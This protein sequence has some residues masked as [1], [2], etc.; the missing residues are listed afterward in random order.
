MSNT[1]NDPRPI[2]QTPVGELLGQELEARGWSQADFA[3]VL[4]RPTQFVSEIIT[5]KKEI[6]RESAAQIG[7]AL[8]QSPE[9]WLKLQDQYLLSEQAKNATTQAKLDDVRRR[10]GLNRLAPI[11]LLQKR[12]VLSGRTLDE[13]EAEV[14]DLFDLDSIDSSPEFAAAAKRANP[15]QDISMLQQAWVACVRRQARKA[16]PV[17]KY[18]PGILAKLAASLPRSMKTPEDFE[19]LPHH[20]SEAGVHL[21]YVEAFPGAKIDGCAMVV[22]G[23]PVIGLSGRGKRLDKVLFTLLHEIAHILLGHAS[24]DQL[25]VEDLDDGHAQESAREV[26]A[27]QEAVRWIFPGGDPLIPSRIN[28]RWVDQT[29]SELGL[30]QIILI[31]SLQ[32]RGRMDWRT[33]LAKNAPSVS[34]VLPRWHMP[35]SGGLRTH[36]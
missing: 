32:K 11:Q 9:F 24:A 28:A 15:G 25:I 20:F 34:E 1:T 3:A 23:H 2:D 6:T 30:S 26:K 16:L 22:D 14:K 7:A 29:A 5:G 10:A 31:G 12:N 4:D 27:N 13:L 19:D 17:D 21:V 8:F 36:R 18:S 35:D 33:T